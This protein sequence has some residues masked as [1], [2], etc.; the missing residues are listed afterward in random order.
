MPASPM[1]ILLTLMG[2]RFEAVSKY[3]VPVNEAEADDQ[4]IIEANNIVAAAI[5]KTTEE[6]GRLARRITPYGVIQIGDF[7]YI[8]NIA[9]RRLVGGDVEQFDAGGVAR[10]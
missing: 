3:L 8:K 6:V 10:R 1:S 4:E 7:Y 2:S 9:G 5:N